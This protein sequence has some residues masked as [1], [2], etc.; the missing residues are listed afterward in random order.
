MSGPANHLTCARCGLRIVSTSDHC[1]A[2]G[3]DYA[4]AEST[5][6]ASR[7]DVDPGGRGAPIDNATRSKDQPPIFV[8]PN[9]QAVVTVP[10]AGGFE[11]LLGLTRVSGVVVNVDGP[12]AVKRESNWI[13]ATG[14]VLLLVAVAVVAVPIGIAITIAGALFSVFFRGN[15]SRGRPGIFS[16][17]AQAAGASF[18]GGQFHRRDD[19]VPVRDI[20]VRDAQRLEH[21]IRVEGDFVAGNFGIGDE[22]EVSGQTRHG[23]LIFRCGWNK[24]T[25][26]KIVSRVR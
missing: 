5:T 20:R 2:C 15:Y 7:R 21:L 6:Q 9:E 16:W 22:V 14:K 19:G 11:R 23:T 13:A 8:G 18:L 4:R 24:R 26:T 1:P 3:T 17:F 25:R 10:A 12:Y